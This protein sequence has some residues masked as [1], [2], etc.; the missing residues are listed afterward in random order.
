MGVD[1]QEVLA[2]VDADALTG[3]LTHRRSSTL[4]MR[5]RCPSDCPETGTSERAG[6]GLTRNLGD[7]G[8]KNGL[9]PAV[10]STGVPVY[11]TPRS[12]KGSESERIR[13]RR[14]IGI[15]ASASAF[16][17]SRRRPCRARAAGR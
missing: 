1:V 7:Q 13:H 17:I 6:S 11:R 2:D 12:Y 4:V 5:A 14:A 8:C 16:A 9:P 15:T 10:R 3:D